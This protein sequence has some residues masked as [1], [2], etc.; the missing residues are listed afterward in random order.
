MP[1]V[2]ETTVYTMD[3]L[4]ETGREA[5]RA[6]YRDHG[7]DY[8]WWDFVYDDFTEI[9]S[10]MGLDIKATHRKNTHGDEYVH[11]HIFF[12]GFWSQ[13]DGACFEGTLRYR[14][15]AAGRV[16][17]HAPHD[18]TLHEIVDALCE[19]QKRNF[20]QLSARICHQGSYH[21]E[22]TM[23]IEVERDHPYH[24]EMTPDAEGIVTNA[25]RDLARW[26]YRRLNDAYEDLTC[27]E[28]VDE[29]LRANEY[30]FTEDG[31]RFG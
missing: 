4:G 31:R 26:L 27:D 7:F 12:T 8:D 13:G 28:T 11:H 22:Y 5:A 23:H 18:T 30:T 24:Q 9:A 10:R 25:M 1:H 17:E 19:V 21:H 20:Y 14:E 3:E 6:W 2:I 15:G 16:R 29:T